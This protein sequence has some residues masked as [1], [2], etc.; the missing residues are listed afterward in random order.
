MDTFDELISVA[1]TLMAP[2][3]CPW[4]RKQTFETTRSSVVEEVYELVEAINTGDEE[5]IIDELGDLFF[6]AVFFCKIAEREGRFRME[7][8]LK[9][10]RDK[11]VYRH[12]HVFG[13]AQ[14]ADVEEVKEQWE[15]L[16][17]QEKRNGKRKSAIDGIPKELPSLMRGYKM[18]KKMKQSGYDIGAENGD[19]SEDELGGALYAIVKQAVAA[20]VDP[21]MA[22]LKI[23]QRQDRKFR[24]WEQ[25]KEK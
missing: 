7:E 2:G 18:L 13:D 24:Q 17:K 4:D 15:R 22:M 5:A 1:D 20:G 16:K 19:A 11:L 23:L 25:Q 3:G 9:H 21:E 12:P 8:V 6:N 10:I 14:C